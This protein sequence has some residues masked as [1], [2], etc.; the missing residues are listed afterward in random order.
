M[1]KII[2]VL[3]LALMISISTVQVFAVAKPTATPTPTP[4]P[5][6]NLEQQITNLKDKIASRVAQ[7]KLVDKRGIIGTVTDV[8]ATQITLTDIK[9]NTRFVDVDELTKFSSPSAK[10]TFGI[11][12]ITKGTTLGVLGL[13]NKESRRILARFVDVIVTPVEFSG[14]V[15]DIDTKNYTVTV[16]TADKKTYSVD[17]ENI[18]KTYTYDGTTLSKSGFSKIDKAER[19]T[20]IG[21]LDRNNAS[22]I[23][24]TRIILFPTLP[25]DPSI[26]IVNPEDLQLKGTIVPATGSGMKLTPLKK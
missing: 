21:F 12:D 13:Y 4:N 24:A 1:K 20:V 14:A 26:T 8:N 22:H 3:F 10:S 23:T 16:V 7:L 19:I 6:A 17:I 15:S 18:T 2:F 25:I 5:A 9:G 11:S